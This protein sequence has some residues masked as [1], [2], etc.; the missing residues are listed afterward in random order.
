MIEKFRD[1]FARSPD[2]ETSREILEAL[3]QTIRE[4]PDEQEAAAALASY[5]KSGVDVFTKLPFEVGE[6]GM[7]ATAP[8]LRTA[9]LDLLVTL[10][11]TLALELARTIMN[12][13]SSPDEYAIALRNL[14]WNDLDGDL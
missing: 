10:D 2:A 9:L 7:L 13:T 11:P 6:E 14:A 1:E 4:A 12:Q 5:L 3:R 8:T